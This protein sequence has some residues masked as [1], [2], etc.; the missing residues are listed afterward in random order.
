[1]E[2]FMAHAQKEHLRLDYLIKKYG[3]PYEKED[4]PSVGEEK[5]VLLKN[6]PT[7]I[8]IKINILLKSGKMA[9]KQFLKKFPKSAKMANLRKITSLLSSIK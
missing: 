9:G 1:M 7:S 2:A 4:K 3:N 5:P 8:S 6:D